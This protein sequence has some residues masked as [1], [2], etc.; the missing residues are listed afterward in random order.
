MVRSISWGDSRRF[1]LPGATVSFVVFRPGHLHSQEYSTQSP[2]SSRSTLRRLALFRHEPTARDR[3]A[4]ARKL[5]LG[6]GFVGPGALGEQVQNTF[7]Q[8]IAAE[9]AKGWGSQLQTEIGAVLSYERK[10]R[11]PVLGDNSFGLDIVPQA[12]ATV[13]NIFTYADIGGLLRIGKGL[14][15]DYGPT[16][17]P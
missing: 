10:L 17:A 11:L 15:A 7:H 8:F 6:L 13:G 3:Q 14:A 16:S 12:G 2:S 1:S 9:T 4:N 5:Q